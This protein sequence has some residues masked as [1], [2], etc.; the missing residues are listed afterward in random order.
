MRLL[1]FGPDSGHPI[2]R[3]ASDFVLTPLTEHGGSVRAACIHVGP[4]GSVGEHEATVDQLFCVVGGEGWVSGED[5]VRC[6]I[7]V[8]EAAHWR[9]GERHA[10]GTDTG[11]TAIVLEGGPFV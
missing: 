10:A 11:L 2:A 6:R 3:F 1:S 8:L 4:G 9:S 5:G 7:A